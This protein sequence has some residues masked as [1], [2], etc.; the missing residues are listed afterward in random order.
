ME[1]YHNL[2]QAVMQAAD[3][4]LSLISGI[5]GIPGLDGTATR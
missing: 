3:D 2:K 5:R 4:M 1:P